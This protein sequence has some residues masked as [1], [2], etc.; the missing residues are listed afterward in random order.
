MAVCCNGGFA[1]LV[2]EREVG[3]LWAFVLSIGLTSCDASN[4]SDG[5]GFFVMRVIRAME[6]ASM[7]WSLEAPLPAPKQERNV[8]PTGRGAP[9]RP[10][11]VYQPR[12]LVSNVWIHLI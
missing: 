3:I 6:L 4:T 1:A 9:S 8:R 5:I 2:C 7:L 11:V 12:N 10:P